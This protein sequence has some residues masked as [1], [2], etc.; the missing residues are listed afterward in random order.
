MSTRKNITIHRNA[1]EHHCATTASWFIV[2]CSADFERLDAVEPGVRAG[3][4]GGGATREEAMSSA[5]RRAGALITG[6]RVVPWADDDRPE[7]GVCY[8]D[9]AGQPWHGFR[10]RKN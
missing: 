8:R 10:L 4:L 2:V 7:G 3:I 1:D 9:A 6:V 5:C